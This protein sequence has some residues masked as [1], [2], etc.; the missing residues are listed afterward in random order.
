MLK[1]T[2]IR[3]GP[4]V[5]AV[6]CAAALNAGATYST[7]GLIDVPTDEYLGHLQFEFD[8]NTALSGSEEV[9]SIGCLSVNLG[10]YQLAELGLAVNSLWEKPAFLGNVKFEVIDEEHYWKYQPGFSVGMDNITTITDVSTAGRRHPDDDE[11]YGMSLNDKLSFFV[12]STKHLNPVGVFHVGWGRGRFVGYGPYSKYFHGIFLSCQRHIFGPVEIMAEA[13]GR[14]INVG[15]RLNF[16]RICVVV[17]GEKLEQI[18]RGFSPYFS[19][20]LEVSNRRLYTGSAERLALRRRTA[21]VKRRIK[22]ILANVRVEAQKVD[23]LGEQ[24]TELEK[25]YKGKELDTKELE[26]IRRELEELRERTHEME[27]EPGPGM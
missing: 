11:A 14:D 9:P 15:A 20:A 13:D 18:G 27:S 5:C 1:K 19:V 4:V 2:I 22:E 3:I 24:L 25:E 10:L 7:S 26:Q 16:G 21:D 17:A 23:D 12:V 8:F 6:F